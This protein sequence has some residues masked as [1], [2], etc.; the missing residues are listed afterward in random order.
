MLKTQNPTL[1]K[2][3]FQLSFTLIK[4][5][6]CKKKKILTENITERTFNCKK[7]LNI[8]KKVL[9]FEKKVLYLQIK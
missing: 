2:G 3:V 9:F 4:H 6:F 8:W 7:A 1:I 5:Y